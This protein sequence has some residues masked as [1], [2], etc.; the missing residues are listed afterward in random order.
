MDIA[1]P[2][3]GGS[4]G[5]YTPSRISARMRNAK[6][7]DMFQNI[8]KLIGRMLSSTEISMYL[9]WIDDFKFTPEVIILLVEYC[10]SKGKLDS[11]YIEKVA[12]NWHD[13]NI[14]S[15]DDAQKNIA[16]HEGKYNNYRLV[17]D[18]LGLKEN[19]L[20]K[21]QQEL[22]DKWFG[23]WGFSVE[24]VLEACKIC[25]LRINEPNFSYIDGILSNWNKQGVKN[26]K[27]IA[28][29]GRKSG[30]GVKFKAPV[31]SFNSYDQRTYD[32]NELERKLLGR[33]DE[34]DDAQ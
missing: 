14:I 19:E 30:K 29:E 11:R 12:L 27:D 13:E 32:I 7:K 1:V 6:I 15:V 22:L 17:L 21:P 33:D 10:K 18:F 26:I 20:M 28:N 31:N 9:S 8:E 5:K 16:Q 34:A 24:V 25:S 23:Q 3:D 4:Q 2:Y